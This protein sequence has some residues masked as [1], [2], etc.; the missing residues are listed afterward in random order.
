MDHLSVSG[1]IAQYD[2]RHGGAQKR[3][4]YK[5]VWRY[6]DGSWAEPFDSLGVLAEPDPDEYLRLHSV[7][8]YHTARLERAVQE[9]ENFRGQLLMSSVPDRDSVEQLKKLKAIVEQRSA[10]LETAK[11][12]LAAT[13][14]ARRR[15]A[16]KQSD[17][18]RKQELESFKQDV[19]AMRV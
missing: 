9:F 10:E 11:Q 6:E 7:M 13:P 8:L 18:Q 1:R 5:G 2:R 14:E 12:N 19:R 3:I 15:A 4:F 17:I 16:W